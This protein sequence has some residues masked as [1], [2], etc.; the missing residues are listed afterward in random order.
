MQIIEVKPIRFQ[1]TLQA[2]GEM[3]H[4]CRFHPAE[5]EVKFALFCDRTAF[6]TL[7]VCPKCRQMDPSQLQRYLFPERTEASP[8]MAHGAGY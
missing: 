8:V 3:C 6:V 7:R 5:E 4:V 2:A 1:N